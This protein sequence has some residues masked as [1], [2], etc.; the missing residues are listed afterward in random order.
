M[1]RVY[2]VTF[3]AVSVAAAQDLVFIPGPAAGKIIRILRRWVGC[4]DSTI[5]ASQMLELRERYLPATVTAGTS[6]TTGITPSKMDQGDATCSIT[7]AGTNNTG[8]ATTTGTAVIL[9][10]MGVH[11]FTGYNETCLV[12]PPINP[13]TAYVFELVAAPFNA[14]AV[15]LSGGVEFEEIG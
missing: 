8:K 1:P 3:E 2:K 9:N 12:R 10:E 14:A 15:H 11:L 13:S 7:T 4:T 5:P 6:G